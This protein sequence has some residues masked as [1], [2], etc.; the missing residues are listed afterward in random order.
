MK[1][2]TQEMFDTFIVI[3]GIKQCPTGDYSKIKSFGESCSFWESCRFGESCSFVESCSFENGHVTA[4]NLQ[5][6]YKFSGFSSREMS[7]TY[8]FNCVDGVFV[9]CGCFFGSV[10]DFKN[11]V[12]KEKGEDNGY[13]KI[14]DLYVNEIK[15][16]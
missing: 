14:V 11:R 12:I 1:K 7:E 15:K 6:F 3:C 13:L 2:V 9:R 8:I 5:P 10:D 4:T 16:R